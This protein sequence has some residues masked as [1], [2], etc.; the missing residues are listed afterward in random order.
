MSF[1]EKWRHAFALEPALPPEEDGL[2]DVLE[3][4]ALQVVER[5][6]ETPAILFLETVR[7]LNFIGS[8]L[9]FAASPLVGL[10]R[11]THQ[12]NEVACALEHRGA[13]ERLV[14]RIEQLSRDTDD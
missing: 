9:M 14:Q 10:F 11:N 13:V 6:M 4:F 3:R 2:P 7:P 8:Q 5:R 1:R 12:L